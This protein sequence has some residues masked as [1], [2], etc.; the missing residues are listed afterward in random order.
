M[1]KK[2]L[3]RKWWKEAIF[4]AIG[5]YKDMSDSRLLFKAKFS[6]LIVEGVKAGSSPCSI[7]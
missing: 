1:R 2:E 6:Y 5:K 7:I 4:N 3:P